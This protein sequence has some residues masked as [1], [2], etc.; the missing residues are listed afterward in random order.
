MYYHVSVFLT[1][2]F[3]VINYHLFLYIA[4]PT[5]H[6]VYVYVLGAT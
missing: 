2:F 5:I 1:L 6:T 3:L 4:T